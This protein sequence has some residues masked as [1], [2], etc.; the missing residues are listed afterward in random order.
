MNFSRINED[1]SPQRSPNQYGGASSRRQPSYENDRYLDHQPSASN[2]KGSSPLR[3]RQRSADS[4][5]MGANY[6]NETMPV[7]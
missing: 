2:R 4:G 6:T 7:F 5:G 1:E 3:V